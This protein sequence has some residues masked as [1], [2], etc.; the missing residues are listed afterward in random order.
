MKILICG[1]GIA[2]LFTALALSGRGNSI[3][4]IER[5]GPPPVAD[6]ETDGAER[7][8]FDWKRRGAAQFRHPHAFLGLM[9]SL[10]EAHHPELLEALIEAGARPIRFCDMLSPA[11]R[12]AYVPEPGD[13][14]LW[15]MS[16][17]RAT[18]ERV[19]HAHVTSL[20]DVRLVSN[21]VVEDLMVTH[22]GDVP[23]VAGVKLDGGESW[24]ADVTLDAS[25]RTSKAP[26]WLAN[27]GIPI[28]EEK[29]DAEIQYFTRYY[30]LRDGAKEPSRE[31]PSGN[32]D[33]GYLKFG[34]F[35][36][37]NGHFAVILCL[38]VAEQE[39]RA[40]ILRPE[41]FD[42][43][44]RQVP[45][46][47]RWLDARAVPSTDPAGIGDIHAVWRH[48]V[49][50]GAP[51]VLDFF[52]VGDA[53]LRTNPLYGRGCSTS[54][55]HAHLLRDVLDE[56]SDPEA[57]A[58]SFSERTEARIRPIFD[59]SLADDK[60]GIRKAL[61]ITEGLM[62]PTGVGPALKGA[63]RDAVSA[64]ARE[65]IYVMRGVARSMN[66]IE[67]PGAFMADW[68]IRGIIAR[69]LLRG[70]RRNQTAR[71]PRGPDRDTMLRYVRSLRDDAAVIG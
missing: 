10:I 17:R 1:S 58:L 31:G 7:A 28:E 56:I 34:I 14:K 12:E 11:L 49:A 16:C 65:N 24:H 43:I 15:V 67:T 44:C 19:L 42:D 3:T 38:P 62:E 22:E 64:A 70:R 47:A 25:G 57:R 40:A 18:I 61:Q 30:R 35:P 41:L 33:L 36:G 66:L 26:R 39:L 32:G 29:D 23:R 2:G 55:L 69:F 71:T 4:I 60:R 8:F 21:R 6:N 54:L 59:A 51:K 5:D 20:D 27:H 9:C 52:A 63:F 68:K 50:D 37:D 45:G 46:L 53:H 48:F 13:E